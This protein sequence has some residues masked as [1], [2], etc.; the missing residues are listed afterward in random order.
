MRER[1]RRKRRGRRGQPSRCA[2]R[3]WGDE[4]LSRNSAAPSGLGEED[5]SVTRIEEFGVED[6]SGGEGLYTE[7]GSWIW[8]S[9]DRRVR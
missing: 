7:G 9:G 8:N 1:K 5:E 2:D 6:V 3:L 4:G